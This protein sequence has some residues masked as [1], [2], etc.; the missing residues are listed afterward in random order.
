V[1]VLGDGELTV[2]LTVA[3]HRFSKSA[4]EK[5]VAAGGTVVKL[6]A[7]RTPA[8]RVAALAAAKA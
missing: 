4:E 7:K 1:K 5:I 2:K 6:P 3:A 8:E